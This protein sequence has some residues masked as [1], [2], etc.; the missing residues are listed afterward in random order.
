MPLYPSPRKLA[1]AYLRAGPSCNIR[2]RHRRRIQPR[3]VHS[4]LAG[5][6]DTCIV[7]C[8]AL[9]SLWF[10]CLSFIIRLLAAGRSSAAAQQGCS[11]RNARMCVELVDLSLAARR[12]ND[13]RRAAHNRA[14]KRNAAARYLHSHCVA[15]R[16]RASR[17]I[18]RAC[19]C[20]CNNKLSLVI[21]GAQKSRLELNCSPS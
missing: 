1:P 17:R 3:L 14:A 18:D 10:W 5:G 9:E 4:I 2:S 7:T 12:Y 21:H 11:N 20:A 16:K 15:Y 19:A 6:E 13:Q 8:C